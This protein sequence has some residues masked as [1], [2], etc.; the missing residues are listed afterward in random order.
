MQTKHSDPAALNVGLTA[1]EVR[2]YSLAKAIV[3]SVTG[4]WADAG[5]SAL[6]GR[7]TSAGVDPATENRSCGDSRVS[8]N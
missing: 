1:K 7:T 5:N 3:A 6:A 2:R 4:N 8:G